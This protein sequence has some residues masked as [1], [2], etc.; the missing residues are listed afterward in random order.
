[1]GK[2]VP[3]PW[4]ED[5]VVKKHVIN[6]LPYILAFGLF[7]YAIWSNGPG[8]KE[9]FLD[10]TEPLH[11]EFLALGAVILT[12]SVP[13]RSAWYILVRLLNSRSPSATPRAPVG[14]FYNTIM[15]GSIG[16]ISSRPYS[17]PGVA[18]RTVA[19][20]WYHGPV[21]AGRR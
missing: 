18:R 17:S 16:A 8:L 1:V 3:R 20:A 7:A 12:V 21:I 4:I 15:P 9:I 13:S 19:V 5:A 10:R 14:F 6:V 2:D 11:Y